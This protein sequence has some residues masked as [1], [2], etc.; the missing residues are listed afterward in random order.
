LKINNFPHKNIKNY[1]YFQINRWDIELLNGQIIKL[2]EKKI[3]KS[4]K[5]ATE[6]I[7]NKNFKNYSLFDLRINDKIIVE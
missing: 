6:L 4:I 7:S 3:K 1:Y 5:H 2:P